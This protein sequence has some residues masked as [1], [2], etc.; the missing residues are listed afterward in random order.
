MTDESNTLSAGPLRLRFFR[1]GDRFAHS[2][3]LVDQISG[4]EHCLLNSQEGD[5]TDPWPPSP[6][7]QNF[8]L[9][10]RSG[11]ITVAL[12]VGMAGRSHWSLAVEALPSG[13]FRFDAAC[14]TGE[15]PLWL[16]STYN[17]DGETAACPAVK[18]VRL[19]PA[20][21]FA[22]VEIQPTSTATVCWDEVADSPKSFSLIPSIDQLDLP[23]TIRWQYSLGMLG[24]VQQSQ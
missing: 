23:S 6:P 22:N 20:L 5:D 10:H 14:R 2:V 15:M 1:G 8:H 4:K 24:K 16:G 12:A 7:L 9:E 18:S 21:G 3:W 11:G 19:K 13:E 17:V